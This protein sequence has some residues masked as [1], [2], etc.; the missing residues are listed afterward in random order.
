MAEAHAAR[1]VGAGTN[2]ESTTVTGF[3]VHAFV[4][5][6]R[7]VRRSEGAP[8]RASRLA[9]L[10]R[11]SDGRTFAAVRDPYRPA[12]FVRE[13]DRA[14]VAQYDPTAADRRTID[15]E[16][17]LRLAFDTPYELRRAAAD[18]GSRGVRT[19]EA[20]LSPTD[21]PLMDAHIHGSVQ[22][23][24][25][26]I[27]GHHVDLV[28]MNPD[29]TPSD[30]EP[31]LTVLSLDIET[32]PRTEQILAVSLVGG[33]GADAD[34]VHLVGEVADAPSIVSHADEASL[35]R[36]LVRRIVEID[37]DIITGWNVVDFDFGV[38]ARR[39]ERHGIPFT[40]AR[41]HEPARFLPSTRD[42]SG[43]RRNAAVSCAGRQ[44]LDALRLV[45]YGP[46]RFS[47]RKLGS[48]AEAVLGEGKT[49][50][51]ETS[52]EKIETLLALYRDDP[53]AFCDYCRQDARLVLRILEKTGLLVLT[54][55]R[56]R[57]IGIGLNR[58][59]T[60]IP[61]FDFLYL[62]AMHERG[63][64][65]PTLGVDRLPQGEAP[66]G[67]II[68]PQPGLFH[69][70]LVFDFK[71]LYPSIMRTF[72]IDPVGYVDSEEGYP[73]GT[74]PPPPDRD[75]ITAPNGAR[76]SR[77][78]SILPALL[79]RFWENRDAAK[80]SG[81]AVASYVYKI[82]MNSFYGVLGSPG[83]RFAGTPLSGA[84]TGFGQY[85]LHWARDRFT[86]QGLR[87]LYGDTDSLFVLHTDDRSGADPE[88]GDLFA[89]GE[90]LSSK[91]NDTLSSFV[92]ESYRVESK[93]ELEFEKVYTRF[94]LPRIRHA[95]VGAGAATE[96]IRGRAKGY[97]GL[98]LRRDGS[99]EEIEIKG[100]EAIRSDW[101][102]AAAALQREL[103]ELLFADAGADAVV[104]HVRDTMARLRDGEF[105]GKLVYSRRLRKPVSA[106]T[107]TRPPHVQAA[108]LLPPDEQ[109][110][111]IEYLVTTEGPQP[112]SQR[113]A[114]IDHA[115]YLERQIRPIAE[116]I[117]EI[118]GIRTQELFDPSQQLSLF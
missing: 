83:C 57:L 115:H 84:I 96:E 106:Y 67:A 1:E 118:L 101:T 87:V 70:V 36:S 80:R 75:T 23:S 58:A 117:C 35:L 40:I 99:T 82:I 39:L 111:T 43:S 108:A 110:G 48:V 19:Y 66:G 90:E 47:D 64:V 4:Q 41:S 44:V 104:A 20:D 116:P 60:S 56:C 28:F 95:T 7:G 29:L 9:L 21:H 45:R 17:V 14:A 103:L 112:P 62:E 63:L 30:W 102:R 97:A 18:A 38:I 93:L 46:Q 16:R 76:F 2:A 31:Q 114:G 72:G 34:E 37:P 105:D 61:A 52:T 8:A 27:P 68:K 50:E 100:M 65:G 51:A 89:R 109:E 91:L 22:V 74:P 73:E 10:G 54:L 86:E 12:F 92:A 42:E 25:V 69:N 5:P 13:T 81:D 59:W 113:T 78:A 85:I 77:E 26:A 49:V 71:S 24:G 94:Y 79:D 11:L 33:W 15:G 107:S 53:V 55:E 32:D 88:A 6:T 3:I 98:P